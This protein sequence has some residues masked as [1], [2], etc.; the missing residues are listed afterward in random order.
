MAHHEA[1]SEVRSLSLRLA[2]RPVSSGRWT[3]HRWHAMGV[4][5]AID[6]T[7]STPQL[8]DHVTS[9][10]GEEYLWDNLTLELF[11]D[12]T[13]HYQ[14]N[15]TAREPVLFVICTPDEERGMMRPTGLSL[16]QDEAAS[17]LE[18]DDE[19]ISLPLPGDLRA[20]ADAYVERVGV[21][22]PKKR[23]RASNG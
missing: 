18:V 22:A 11:P 3:S 5:D 7:V 10:E 17:F 19:V 21:E 16:S 15:L 23:R 1:G 14:F 9:P 4:S 20:W 12:E 8:L 13:A 2:R 6:P